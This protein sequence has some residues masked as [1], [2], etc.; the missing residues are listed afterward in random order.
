MIKASEALE[1]LKKGNQAYI[2]EKPMPMNDILHIQSLSEH[3]QHPFAVVI[4]CS[5]SR[6]APEI[7][8]NCRLGDLF[9]IRTAGN[10][11]SSIEMG[12]IEYAVA[13]LHTPLVVVLGHTHCGAVES[14]C[15]PHEGCSQSLQVL[16]SVIEPSVKAARQKFTTLHDI[17]DM[18]EDLN[19]ENS[20]RCIAENPEFSSL[21]DLKIVG[22]K[23]DIK[24]GKILYWK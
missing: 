13:H 24:T 16:L 9:T 8:F 20:I 6:V 12:S 18:A 4:T 5:D 14:T 1:K 21:P 17:A 22:A 19:I 15:E 23:Y 11:I 10:V 3:G 2:A 7:I